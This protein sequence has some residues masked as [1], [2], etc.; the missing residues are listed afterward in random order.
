MNHRQAVQAVAKR[1]PDL[2]QH[3][4]EDILA[5]LV[6]V[7]SGA[8]AKSEEVVIRDFGTLGIEVQ[9]LRSSGVIR[10]RSDAP[11]KLKR[12]YFR[13]RPSPG[14]RSLVERKVKEQA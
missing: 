6:E 8:L 3:Q 10:M 7:W 2:T 4:V 9:E 14:M 13:F 12:L 11:D 5:V 1:F